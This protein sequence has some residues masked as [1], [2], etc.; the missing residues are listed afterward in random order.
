MGIF[1]IIEHKNLD[2]ESDSPSEHAGI[3]SD[4]MPYLA[5]LDNKLVICLDTK[6][7]FETDMI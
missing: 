5:K 1:D 6:S 4:C 3:I 7:L 2:Q